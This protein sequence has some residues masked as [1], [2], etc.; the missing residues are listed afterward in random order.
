MCP[1]LL[2]AV[3]SNQSDWGASWEVSDAVGATNLGMAHRVIRSMRGGGR[4]NSGEAM[5]WLKL[6][7]ASQP[8]GE[9]V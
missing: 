2:K 4:P 7:K 5:S 8:L 1:G 6:G 3:E 9:A